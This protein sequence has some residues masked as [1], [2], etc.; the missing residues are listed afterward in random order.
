MFSKYKRSFLVISK[1]NY[2]WVKV[3]L[4]G[5]RGRN[6]PDM[7]FFLACVL[8]L[9]QVVFARRLINSIKKLPCFPS[10]LPLFDFA[11]LLLS[12]MRRKH[13]ELH[14]E[15]SHTTPAR[16]NP[17]SIPCLEPLDQN[18][19]LR[20]IKKM[21]G[22]R[23]GLFFFFLYKGGGK[24]ADTAKIRS[25]LDLILNMGMLFFLTNMNKQINI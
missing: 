12:V 25:N 24:V 14:M 19:E 23:D 3:A 6:R 9:L 18:A 22:F 20:T 2:L 4:V 8:F 1:I 7:S 16:F 10:S 15:D 21:R 11:A 5:V 13:S 17:N